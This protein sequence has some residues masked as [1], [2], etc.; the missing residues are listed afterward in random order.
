MSGDASITQ[1]PRRNQGHLSGVA[2]G[3]APTVS[4]SEVA[5]VMY[6]ELRRRGEADLKGLRDEMGLVE[7]VA[8]RAWRHLW[9]LGLLQG[10]VSGAEV[11]AVDPEVALMR[12][13]EQ[14]HARLE[15]YAK[16]I[17]ALQRRAQEISQEMR[18]AVLRETASV[19]VQ[20]LRDRRHRT[21]SLMSLNATARTDTWSMHPG[22]LPPQ[23]VL[24]TSLELDANLIARG[25]RVRAIYG[26]TVASGQRA[27]G[28][29][30]QLAALGAEVRLA[31][32]VPFDLLLFDSH[33]ALIPSNPLSLTDPMLLLHDRHLMGTY[34]AIYEDTWLHATPY[35]AQ[36][37]QMSEDGLTE[38]QQAVLALMANGL[39]DEQ[40]ARRLGI[41]LRTTG[42]ITANIID[43]IGGTGRFHTG[44]LAAF[45]GLVHPEVADKD[46]EMRNV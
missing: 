8:E 46:L 24:A 22:P 37:P 28:Y 41:S 35:S 33:T 39:T 2:P 12:L 3:A 16:E 30:N 38:K 18:P 17:E 1:F 7:D 14:Q 13:F 29:L 31:Q 32:R 27:R 10:T 5:M 23:E 11:T 43:H 34:L 15:A 44:V 40:I 20:Y 6:M 21:E 19:Q 45:R 9:D 25:I 26:H 42:R 36:S 4:V